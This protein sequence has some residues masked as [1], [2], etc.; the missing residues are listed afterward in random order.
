MVGN[1]PGNLLRRAV[2][3]RDFERFFLATS[4]DDD[5][6]HVPRLVASE[7]FGV[8]INRR[9]RLTAEA[10]DDVVGLE[11]SLLGRTPFADARQLDPLTLSS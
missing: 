11:P 1:A 5:I 3:Q 8:V 4:F 2:A 7:A 6:H 9:D 10:N